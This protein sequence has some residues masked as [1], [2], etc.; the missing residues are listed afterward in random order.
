MSYLSRGIFCLFSGS[1]HQR[2]KFL[3][4]HPN[5]DQSAGQ[6]PKFE[7]QR[8]LEV[9]SKDTEREC[10]EDLG[11]FSHSPVQWSCFEGRLP[12]THLPKACQ[13]RSPVK[14]EGIGGLSRPSGHPHIGSLS[15]VLDT[16]WK[17]ADLIHL[18]R[19]RDDRKSLYGRTE[20]KKLRDHFSK[21]PSITSSAMCISLIE[22]QLASGQTAVV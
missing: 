13:R 11:R 8:T 20:F 14:Q 17:P 18:S 7:G 9:S 6:R 10:E 4:L 21:P 16:S 15:C 3:H 5:P 12:P 22:L 19:F 2:L 1:F